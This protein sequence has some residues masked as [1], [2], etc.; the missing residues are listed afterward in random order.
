MDSCK[1]TSDQKRIS[2]FVRH[3][4]CNRKGSPRLPTGFFAKVRKV[5]PKL[6][7]IPYLTPLNGTPLRS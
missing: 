4:G 1:M 7:L 6:V 3:Y 2:S 5:G